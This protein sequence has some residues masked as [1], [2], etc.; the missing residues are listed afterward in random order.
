MYISAMTTSPSFLHLRLSTLGLRYFFSATLTLAGY[1]VFL[2]VMTTVARRQLL[3][4]GGTVDS[5]ETEQTMGWIGA[6][7][8]EDAEKPE[9]GSGKEEVARAHRARIGINHRTKQSSCS[10]P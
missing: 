5:E 4:L 7:M 3:D 1:R 8:G 9:R 2:D 10:L 6:T